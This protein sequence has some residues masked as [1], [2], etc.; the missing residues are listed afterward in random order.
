MSATLKPLPGFNWAQISWGGPDEPRT[1]TCS[2]CDA[3]INGEDDDDDHVPLIM[4]NDEGWCAEF[5]NA[6]QVRWWGLQP[7]NP[8]VSDLGQI[9]EDYDEPD[10]DDLAE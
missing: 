1:L 10:R 8:A 5:C 9:Y 6:C 4:W 3:P 7:I 2:Y